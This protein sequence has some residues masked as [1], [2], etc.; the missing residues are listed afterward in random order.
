M[1]YCFGPVP[2]RRLGLSL[3]VDILPMKTCNLNCIYCELGASREMTSIRREYI[4]AR[5]IKK[6]ITEVIQKDI[7]FDAMTF[8]ASGETTLHSRL[9]ELLVFARGHTSKPLVVITNGTT[10]SD[11]SVRK[12]LGTA[13]IVM[14]SLDAATGKTFRQINRPH[15][16]LHV[17]DIINGLCLFRK[18][19][20]GLIWLEILLVKGINDNHRDIDA[21]VQAVKEINPDRIQLN[22]V[23]RPPAESWAAPLPEG[24]MMKICRRF[25]NKAEVIASFHK[26]GKNGAG[27]LFKD[28]ILETL[29]RRP[30]S[31]EDIEEMMGAD[32]RSLKKI[33]NFMEHEGIIKR[34]TVEGRTFFK[35]TH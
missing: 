15:K 31:F 14:P 2:S 3:G 1:K 28:E 22:T 35:I 32:S 29:K 12:E 5:E 6:E 27:L 17:D 23:N 33:L 21:L 10:L 19:F 9:G 25:G 13:D 30:I 18:D 11:E 20:N 24:E 16:N 34:V 4:P 8:S 7:T 26:K